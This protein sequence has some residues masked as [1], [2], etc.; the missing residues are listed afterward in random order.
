MFSSK[1]RKAHSALEGTRHPMYAGS[2]YDSDGQKLKR[3]LED[4]LRT[5]ASFVDHE[6]VRLLTD[7]NPLVVPPVLAI[8]V[9]HAGYIFSG[10]AAGHAYKA[11]QG[12]NIRRVF[13]LGPSHHV[14]FQGIALPKAITF[15][16]PVGDLDVDKDVIGELQEYPMF[17][18]L[19]EVHR[20]EH[21]LEMQL[22][23][24][25]QTLGQVQIVPIVVGVLS[26]SIEIRLLAE[27]LKGFITT[28]DL[29][30]VSSDFTHYGPRYDYQPFNDN[31]QSNVRRLDSKAFELLSHKDLDGFLKFQQETG[32]TICGFYPLSVLMAL[33]PHRSQGTLLKYCTSQD[34]ALEDKANSVSYL[35]IAFSGEGWSNCPDTGMDLSE[36]IKMSGSEKQALLK[37]ARGTIDTWVRERRIPTPEE[38]GVIVT[39]PMQRALGAFV[40]LHKV[41]ADLNPSAESIAEKNGHDGVWQ[42]SHLVLEKNRKQLRGCIGHVWPLKPL[43]MSIVDNAISACSADYRFYPVQP[44]ELEHIRVEVS[45]LTPPR[46]ISSYSDIVL[47]RDGIILVSSGQQAVFL[48][49]VPTEFGWDLTET[50][51][52]LS[53]KAGLSGDDWRTSARFNVFGAEVFG[54]E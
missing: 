49:H 15:A 18:Q 54:E 8:V 21:S 4:F 16:T 28:D 11:V 30:V 37:L 41:Q 22:P 35:A 17:A 50:L 24:I 25:R 20:I 26:D 48:P 51:T 3:Q 10:Q 31:I 13:L 52:Q 2:W 29:V 5:P 19:P 23:F 7:S 44:D 53:L 12:Q 45:V 36:A 27:I 40:T 32:D 46:R 14:G 33:L 43:Y 6:S 47:G 39:Q 38:L 9:P 34:I 1:P 42:G